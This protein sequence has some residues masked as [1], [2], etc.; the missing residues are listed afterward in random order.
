M[1]GIAGQLRDMRANSRHNREQ[2]P[3]AVAGAENTVGLVADEM[4]IHLQR[5]SVR[6]AS[7]VACC[8]CRGRPR[9]SNRLLDLRLTLET[10]FSDFG[11]LVDIEPG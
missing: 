8:R 10:C 5:A 1:A 6:P 7:S 11:E 3:A 9:P 2:D 4:L